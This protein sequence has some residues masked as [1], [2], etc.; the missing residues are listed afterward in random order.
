VLIESVLTLY[1]QEIPQHS[2]GGIILA[3][4]SLIIMP[5]LGKAKL[6][7]GKALKSKALIADAKET[8]ACAFLSVALLL[9]LAANFF[10][11]FWQADPLAGVVI[12]YYLFKEGK[13]N[14]ERECE[15][16]IE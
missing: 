14:W 10:F 1:N 4:L 6:Q 5:L 13:E 11:G 12:V 7:T 16:A 2:L 3:L 15:C 8:F 9:G